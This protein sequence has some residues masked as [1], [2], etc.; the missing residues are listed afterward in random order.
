V[1]LR[2]RLAILQAVLLAV[3]LALLGALLVGSLE[4]ALLGEVDDALDARAATV[5]ADIRAAAMRGVRADELAGLRLDPDAANEFAAPGVYVQVLRPDGSAIAMSK[6]VPP[7]GLPGAERALADARSGRA[8][9]ETVPVGRGERVRVLTVPVGHEEV[10]AIVRVGE[11]LHQIDA[12]LRRLTWLLVAGGSAA[13]LGTSVATWLLVGRALAPLGRIAAA[14]ERIAATGNVNVRVPAPSGGE[15]G[16][17]GRS[18]NRMVER[19]QRLLESQRQLLADTSHELRNP[20]T[21]IRTNLDLLGRDLDEDTRREV[22]A[23]T[24]EEAERMSRLVAD[25]LFL[26]RQ[27]ATAAGELAPFH[28]DALARDVVE[29]FRQISPEHSIALTHAEPLVVRGDP[30]RIRQLLANLLDNAVRYTPPVP[31]GTVTVAVH[32]SGSDAQVV[33][34]DTGVGIAPEHLPRIFDRFYRVDPARSRAT[35]GTGLGLAIVKHVAQAHGGRVTAES[36][37]GRGS[38]FVVTL[39]AEPSWAADGSSSTLTATRSMGS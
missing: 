27:E 39:P 20:L 36:E 21:V 24:E 16:Q 17:L 23:E 11:S 18:F 14:A 29:Q 33:V 1:S 10:S 6:S 2:T 28:L 5:A 9:L 25:L 19:L 30:E 35:G 32:R 22:A 8:S 4:S 15:V 13:L 37:V 31:G 3:G 34:E 12:V 7:G 38:R 26:A